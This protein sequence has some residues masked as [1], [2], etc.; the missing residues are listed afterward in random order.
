M[1]LD[2]QFLSYEG[3]ATL[4]S[5]NIKTTPVLSLD[6]RGENFVDVVSVRINGLAAQDFI[7]LS[8]TRLLVG[9]PLALAGAPILDVQVRTARADLTP[10]STV[11]LDVGVG[12]RVAEGSVRLVQT[13]LKILL[14]APGTD[15]FRPDL[16]GGLALLRGSTDNAG[17]SR[18]KA[19]ASQALE[20]TK[21]QVIALQANNTGLS[22]DE[23]LKSASLLSSSFEGD[24]LG[25]RIRI[26]SMSGEVA[27]AG[28]SL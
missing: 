26:V 1:S 20:V 10:H 3:V 2:L 14:T 22:A 5:I 24:T 6:V 8:N 17:G 18:L 11:H 28:V 7:V 15:V 21:A 12:S 23:R 4:R 27:E 13:F 19:A 9:I 16:G 25:V